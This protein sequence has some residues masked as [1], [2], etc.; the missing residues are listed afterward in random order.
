MGKIW[1]LSQ[2]ITP[3]ILKEVIMKNMIMLFAMVLLLTGCTTKTKIENGQ[4]YTQTW[5]S[6]EWKYSGEVK[7]VEQN[8]SKP[9]ESIGYAA[10]KAAGVLVK[11]GAYIITSPIRAVETVSKSDSNSS[12]AVE[13]SSNEEIK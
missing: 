5:G 4:K 11:T 6:N 1:R 12:N 10:G 2:W 3:P 9:E 7:P 8:A 13:K